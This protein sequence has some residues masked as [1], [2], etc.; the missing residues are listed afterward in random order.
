MHACI[1]KCCCTLSFK[2]HGLTIDVS[3]PKTII[4][5]I[6]SLPSIHFLISQQFTHYLQQT[7]DDLITVK[8][9][10]FHSSPVLLFS[11]CKTK[12]EFHYHSST[13]LLAIWCLGLV[14]DSLSNRDM[15]WHTQNNARL[16]LFVS[17]CLHFGCMSGGLWA[18]L[19]LCFIFCV[20]LFFI[21]SHC[22]CLHESW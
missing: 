22:K 7:K 10:H 11:M 16:S 2:A 17:G 3:P 14:R 5:I 15:T 13:F 8:H 18:P 1:W 4:V 20:S 9:F 21:F 19:R 12:S 6:C